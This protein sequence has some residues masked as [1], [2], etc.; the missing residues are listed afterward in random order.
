MRKFDGC[1]GRCGVTNVAVLRGDKVGAGFS[2]RRSAVMTRST[3]AG[4][5]LVVEGAADE[6]GGG[7]AF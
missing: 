1:P 4:Y 2:N 7:M 6:G 5:A 3:I